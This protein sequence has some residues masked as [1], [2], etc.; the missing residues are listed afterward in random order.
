MAGL[1]EHGRSHVHTYHPTVGGD[2]FGG[3]QAVDPG[4]TSDVHHP[5]A[6]TQFAQTEGVAG[7][8]EGSMQDSGIPSSH[9]SR[10][11]SMRAKGRPVWKWKPFCGWLATS[12][13]SS[14]I[15]WRKT[16]TSRAGSCS[17]RTSLISTPSLKRDHAALC[18]HLREAHRIGEL[19]PQVCKVCLGHPTGD[20]AR[21]SDVH[22][23]LKIPNLLRELAERR[24]PHAVHGVDH[25]RL[26]QTSRL[27]HQG[28]AAVYL[29]AASTR[30]HQERQRG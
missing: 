15:A 10:Y 3:D 30:S 27:S 29:R 2:L 16:F 21:A 8:R 11:S 9:S 28:Y 17:R 22:W 4:T 19:R 14:W 7:T 6:R 24:E 20:R 13:Y 26:N 5:L 25:P 1:L 23:Y 12:S 18:S